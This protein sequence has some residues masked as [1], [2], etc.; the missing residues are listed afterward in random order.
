ALKVGAT[1]RWQSSSLAV[2][3]APSIFAGL[4]EREPDVEGGVAV[5]TN[6]QEVLYLPVTAIYALSAQLGLAGQLAT[7]VP[8]NET[9]D[10]WLLGLS[11]GAQYMVNEQI[12]ADLAF[13]LPALAG[14]P[15]GTGADLRVIT[16]GVGYAL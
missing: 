14:G 7:T 10:T 12:M 4:T 11:V 1:G 3:L 8:F 13:T 9:G 2:E 16:L 15:D 5:G 6:N